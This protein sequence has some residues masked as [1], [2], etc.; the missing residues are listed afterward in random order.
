[1]TG[2]FTAAFGPSLESREWQQTHSPYHFCTY[3]DRNYLTRGLALYQSLRTHC[4][5]PFVLWVLCFDNESYAIL[6]HLA[7]D[8]MRLIRLT[9]FEVGDTDLATARGNRSAV[10][11][12]WTCSP[13]LPLY[14]FR[15]EPSIDLITYLDADLFFFSDPQP[16]FD[17]LAQGS[18]LIVG[19]RYAPAHTH[20]TETSGIYNVGL[21]S[22][23]RDATGFECLHWWRE[24]CNEW[25]YARFEDG[26][27]GDQKYLDDWPTRFPGVVVLQHPGAGLAPWN[28]ERYRMESDADGCIRISGVSL[29]FFHF[30]ALKVLS[31]QVVVPT[32]GGYSLS[33][34]VLVR[35][36]IPYL[37][38]LRQAAAVSGLAFADPFA[39]RLGPWK[40]LQGLLFEDVW[41]IKPAVLS[42]MLWRLR[43][44]H[45]QARRLLLAAEK[46]IHHG[47]IAEGGRLLWHTLAR[48]PL[49]LLSK[50][51][52]KIY[53][54]YRTG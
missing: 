31:S 39:A 16:I 3:F 49:F 28:I 12:Y 34:T 50:R 15:Q 38:A 53:I 10:E 41:L 2:P 48:S 43:E 8:G 7:L 13:S 9:D 51:F 54:E 40:L 44:R 45:L 23:R 46:S 11:Y 35:I 22:F 20:Y 36:F 37:R 26:K 29:V 33:Y 6:R 17:E 24:R 1:M 21:M 5:R 52:R 30:H 4:Q 25:C 32:V 47:D 19:H 27:F 14:L 42:A 18:V